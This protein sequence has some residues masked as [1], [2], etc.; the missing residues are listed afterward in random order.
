M[1]FQK[2][3]GHQGNRDWWCDQDFLCTI[4]E[5]GVP[6]DIIIKDLG[7]HY[8]FCPSVEENQPG[9]FEKAKSEILGKLNEK[10]Y[11]I[12]HFKGRLK[13]VMLQ[14]VQI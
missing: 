4:Y 5:S 11:P 7:P 8:N 12:L 1:E 10:N 3:W 2:K 9:T 13:E 6:L 14:E